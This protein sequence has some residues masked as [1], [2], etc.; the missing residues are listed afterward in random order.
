MSVE[1]TRTGG[2]N[3]GDIQP[4][5]GAAVIRWVDGRLPVEPRPRYDPFVRRQVEIQDASLAALEGLGLDSLHTTR[6]KLAATLDT[7]LREPISKL[8]QATLFDDLTIRESAQLRRKYPNIAAVE[9]MADQLHQAL[10]AEARTERGYQTD[11]LFLLSI[12]SGIFVRGLAGLVVLEHFIKDPTTA[13]AEAYTR[14]LF[15]LLTAQPDQE[16]DGPGNTARTRLNWLTRVRGYVPRPLDVLQTFFPHNVYDADRAVHLGIAQ[17]A[18]YAA[19][20]VEGHKIVRVSKDQLRSTSRHVFGE[21]LAS[22]KTALAKLTG[23]RR[24]LSN[25]QS[26]RIAA[27]QALNTEGLSDAGRNAALRD[28]AKSVQEEVDAATWITH[29]EGIMERAEV[30]SLTASG[31]LLGLTAL[32]AEMSALVNRIH[33]KLGATHV[34]LIRALTLS[35]TALS[36]AR[37]LEDQNRRAEVQAQFTQDVNEVVA[38]LQ[39]G[40]DV[41]AQAEAGK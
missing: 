9:N 18:L 33:E 29:W 32:D 13:N 20:A 8:L 2:T 31:S 23:Y 19:A 24:K 30:A 36:R 28:L 5:R 25:A 3:E 12:S 6:P 7:T 37:E 40:R 11:I 39:E 17:T 26:T 21:P 16:Q 35:I 15:E 41:V 22:H 4:S 34:G 27:E 14:A 38:E 10:T 1:G